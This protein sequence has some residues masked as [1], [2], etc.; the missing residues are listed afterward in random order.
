MHLQMD[1]SD[2]LSDWL[3]AAAA[4]SGESPE[5]LA[6]AALIQFLEDREDLRLAEEGSQSVR[7]EG[8]ISLE[9]LKCNL[10]LED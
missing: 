4:E 5:H 3:A 1:L 8:T 9:Q 6:R 2:E 7:E 10:G